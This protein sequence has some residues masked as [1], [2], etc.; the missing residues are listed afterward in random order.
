[1]IEVPGV[2]VKEVPSPGVK[3]SRAQGIRV[4]E[5]VKVELVVFELLVS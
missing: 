2:I 1:M 4:I 5:S 3:T